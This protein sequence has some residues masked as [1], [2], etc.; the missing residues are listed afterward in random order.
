[1]CFRTI[2][3]FKQLL[4][5]IMADRPNSVLREDA[6]CF[7][8]VSYA[9]YHEGAVRF[10]GKECVRIFEVDLVVS[11]D[12]QHVDQSAG[13]VLDLHCNDFGDGADITLIFEDLDRVEWVATMTRT[14]PKSSLSARERARKSMLLFSRILVN[15]ANA[16]GLFSRNT[17]ICLTVICSSC[18]PL[19]EAL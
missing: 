8:I 3:L 16:P 5:I 14:M 1:M 7:L 15:S 19:S 10:F 9:K 11:Q 6:N 4:H 12:V 17:E 13:L 2:T 18:S